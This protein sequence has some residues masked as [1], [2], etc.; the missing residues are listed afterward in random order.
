MLVPLFKQLAKCLNSSHFQ[1]RPLL[2][3]RLAVRLLAFGRILS[4]RKRS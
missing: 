2:V 4:A 3:A 1:V